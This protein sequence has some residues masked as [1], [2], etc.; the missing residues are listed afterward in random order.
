MIRFIRY[1]PK[2]F[3]QVRYPLLAKGRT[4]D[5]FRLKRLLAIVTLKFDACGTKN[6]LRNRGIGAT[7]V[8]SFHVTVPTISIFGATQA[9]T[10]P[11]LIKFA[12]YKK[13]NSPY[14]L[15]S[16]TR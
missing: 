4:I 15:R 5:I 16:M 10:R 12:L 13:Q 8:F 2:G 6:E 3:I 7:K 14:F 11:K 9:N 1:W